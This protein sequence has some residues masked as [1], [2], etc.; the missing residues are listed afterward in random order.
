MAEAVVSSA[1]VA[2]LA[3]A[4]A[5]EV[6]DVLGLHGGKLGEVATYGEEGPIRGVRVQ[7]SPPRVRLRT[8][9]RFGARLDEAADEVRH[10]VRTMLAAQVP[11]LADVTV[12]VHVA[13]VRPSVDETAHDAEASA[14]ELRAHERP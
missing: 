1:V 8:V 14:S 5:Q 9:M 7:L 12:D 6:P 13:D 11:A 4:A 2:R 3:A 10:R